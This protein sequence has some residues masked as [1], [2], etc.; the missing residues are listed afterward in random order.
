MTVTKVLKDPSTCSMTVTAE[1]DAPLDRV[2]QLWAD[3]RLLER[4]WGPPT[5]PATFLKHDLTEGGLVT[6]FMT[7]PEGDQPRGLWR[8][9]EVAP[10]RL[11]V[12]E[13]A[14][15]DETG[16]A[17]A[18]MP[19]TLMRV[20]L[21]ERDV[22]GTSVSIRSTFA[23][24]EAMEQLVAMGMDEGVRQAMGQMDAILLD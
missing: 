7:G 21:T 18:D 2:W 8:V 17:I 1:F 20:D 24:V 12:V 4:W 3:P 13:D 9:V 16:A 22:G 19:V 6:Y 5:Y 11:L 10:P 14:F 15:A 23:S